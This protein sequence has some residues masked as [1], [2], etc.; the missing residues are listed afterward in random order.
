MTRS[1]SLLTRVLMLLVI[2]ASVAHAEDLIVDASGAPGAYPDIGSALA[3]ADLGDR[4]QVR[5]GHYPFFQYYKA[6][7]IIGTGSRPSDVVI[8]EIAF[9][10]SI[11]QLDYSARLSNVQIGHPQTAGQSAPPL[12]L[13]GNEN[14]PGTFVVQGAEIYGGVFLRGGHEGFYVLFANCHLESAPGQGFT[15]ETFYFGG[16]GNALDLQGTRILAANGDPGASLAAGVALRIEGGTRA[17]LHG[18][19]IIG[20]DGLS[21]GLGLATEGSSDVSL[22]LDGGTSISGGTGEAGAGGDGVDVASGHLAVGSA[23]VFGGHGTP[24][25]SAYAGVSPTAA[26]AGVSLQTTPALR[27]AENGTWVSSGESV[28]FELAAP[29]GRIAMIGLALDVELPAGAFVCLDPSTLW[30]YPGNVL[31]MRVPQVGTYHP[32]L[33]LFAQGGWLDPATGQV[34]LTNTAALRV[35]LH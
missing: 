6:V 11:P 1:I 35:D 33:S 27:F 16:P 23:T 10:I 21:G 32:G 34:V 7:P 15:G 22:R 8:D 31:S 13:Y 30:T 28:R 9:H 5:P 20:G 26:P 4:I 24:P 3:A 12:V 29:E 19:D 18:C 14:P 17:R 25:G 2:S